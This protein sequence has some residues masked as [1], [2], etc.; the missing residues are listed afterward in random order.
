VSEHVHLPSPTFNTSSAGHFHP[1]NTLGLA[2]Q[3]AMVGLGA[4][5]VAA[6]ARNSLATG[7]R[8]IL[9]TFSKSGGVVTI[10][11]GAS[12]AYVFTYCSAA[13]LRE[14]KDGWN[15]MW[16]GAATGAVL[17]ART[18]LV[19]AFIGWTVLCGAACGLFGWT[20]ARFNADRKASL[21]QSPKGFVQ[22]DAHQTFWE[23][24]HRRPLSLTVEQL[25]EGR[26]IN[27]VPIATATEAPN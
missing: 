23:V 22:E 13:N 19:P 27:A 6:A 14:R 12:I 18:K 11:T 3:S 2:T 9:T 16:A 24:V 21:E 8:N 20:G 4:G 10:F 5:V 15:H 17:G 25:G 26:G 1:Y 7:P